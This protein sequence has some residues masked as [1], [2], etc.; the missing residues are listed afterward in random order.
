MKRMLIEVTLPDWANKDDVADFIS[1]AFSTMGD[2]PGDY[3]DADAVVWESIGDL[4][5][6]YDKG[7][8]EP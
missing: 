7:D 5:S 1:D 2:D 8:K 3:Y 6:K 4:L